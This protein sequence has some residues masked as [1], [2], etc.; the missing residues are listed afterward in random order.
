MLQYSRDTDN[1][2]IMGAS[3]IRDEKRTQVEASILAQKKILEFHVSYYQTTARDI[4]RQ[5]ILST[6]QTYFVG[7]PFPFQDLDFTKAYN[8]SMVAAVA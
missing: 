4:A 5:L 2:G 1:I 7:H 6:Q 3:V 8:S